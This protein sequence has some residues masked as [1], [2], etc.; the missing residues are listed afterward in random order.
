MKMTA[1]TLVNSSNIPN[2][3]KT[4]FNEKNYSKKKY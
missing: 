1:N 3:K 2:I 4:K